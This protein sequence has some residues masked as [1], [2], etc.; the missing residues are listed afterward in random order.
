VTQPNSGAHEFVASFLLGS[1][2]IEHPQYKRSGVDG[3][4]WASFVA[5][6]AG[7]AGLDHSDSARLFPEDAARPPDGADTAW[8]VAPSPV[9]LR[10]D[11]GEIPEE[12]PDNVIDVLSRLPQELVGFRGPTACQVVGITY[13]Q[14][15]YWARTGLVMPSIRSNAGSGAQRLYSFKDVLLLM[16]VARLIDAKVALESIRGVVDVVRHRSLR[17]LTDMYL[18][19][20]GTTIYEADSPDEVADLLRTGRGVFGVSISG[21]IR[22]VE[23]S[24]SDFPSE[25]VVDGTLYDAPEDDFATG[26][27]VVNRGP[28]TVGEAG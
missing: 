23:S 2:S 13:R 5:A 11:E 6:L 28:R 4:W 1:G 9:I 7:H 19:S 20:D 24:I 8:R 25:Q 12:R 10:L 18:F 16:I 14:L 15:D 21:A 22:E 17:D 27:D 3:G 26:D